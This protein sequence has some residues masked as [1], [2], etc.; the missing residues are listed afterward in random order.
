[1]NSVLKCVFSAEVAAAAAEFLE[2][3]QCAGRQELT[4]LTV[5]VHVF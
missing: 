1:M 2:T 5:R 3:Q 4:E